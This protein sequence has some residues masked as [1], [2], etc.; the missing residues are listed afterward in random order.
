VERETSDD[1]GKD[2]TERGSDNSDDE[3]FAEPQAHQLA[4]GGTTRTQQSLLA[5]AAVCTRC[6]DRRGQQ[7]SEHCTR[8]AK[9]E[10]QH[11]RIEGIASRPGQCRAEPDR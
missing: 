5:P 4:D 9:E 10:E 1:H 6:G 11:L 7:P 2:E 8:N 3:R